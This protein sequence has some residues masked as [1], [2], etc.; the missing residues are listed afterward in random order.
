MFT[1]GLSD[2]ELLARARE[3]PGT[4]ESARDL[5]ELF[6]RYHARVAAWC[7]RLTGDR[8]SAADLAQDVFLKAYKN[9]DSYRH[10]ARFSTWLYSVAR[11]HCFNHIRGLSRRPDA[12]ADE[13]TEE[14]PDP[15]GGSALETLIREHDE[16]RALEIVNAALDETE[17]RVM[18]LHYAEDVRLDV[19]T[20]LLGLTNPSGAKAYV[21]SARRKLRRA[22]ER[23]RLV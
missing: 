2:E 21:V 4:E 15:A 3:S 18:Y 12:N 23:A 19:V 6:G 10:Q 9:L 5:D 14:V 1:G 7:L 11:N 16:S 8:E 22:L 17:R 20:A 13:P